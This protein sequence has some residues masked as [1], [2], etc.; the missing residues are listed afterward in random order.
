MFQR[1]G[2]EFIDDEATGYC[3]GDAERNIINIEP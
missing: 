1:V 3:L 2:N